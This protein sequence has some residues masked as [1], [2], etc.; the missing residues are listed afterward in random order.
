MRA[1]CVRM[2]L[3]G[4]MV[5]DNSYAARMAGLRE[6]PRRQC[7]NTNRNN[8]VP[9]RPRSAFFT[10][11]RSTSA[12]S[13]FDALRAADITP[14]EVPHVNKFKCKLKTFLFKRVYELC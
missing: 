12:R 13:V 5:N 8:D 9:D 14:R 11:A 2:K 6:P 7:L 3:R 4:N 10:P 1:V